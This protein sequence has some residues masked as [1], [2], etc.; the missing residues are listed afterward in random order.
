MEIL[1]QRCYIKSTFLLNILFM[2]N[3]KITKKHLK[4]G[5]FVL[6]LVKLDTLSNLEA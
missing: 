3:M 4:K 6:F 5:V 2:K 1:S